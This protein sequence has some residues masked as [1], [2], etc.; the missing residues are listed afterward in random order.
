MG[1]YSKKPIRLSRFT[2][3]R[4]HFCGITICGPLCLVLIRVLYICYY[5]IHFRKAH[6][7]IGV[8]SIV[9]GE[10]KEYKYEPLNLDMSV[11]AS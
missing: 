6:T 9:Y 10:Q 8:M 3:F 7:C 2:H 11:T 4:M 1:N 5:V